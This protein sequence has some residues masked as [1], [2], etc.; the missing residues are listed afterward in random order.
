MGYRHTP[1]MPGE[2]LHYLDCKPGRTYVDGT[3][4][5][6][7]HAELICETIEPGG[8]LIG[9]DQDPDAISNAHE[10]LKP[11][12]GIVRL[13]HGSFTEIPRFLAQEGIHRVDGI[14]LDLGLSQHHLEAS[15]RGFSFQKDEPL[16]MRM[17][18]RR[19]QKAADI[20]NS[21]TASE[22]AGLFKTYGDERRSK[23]IARKIIAARKRQ[24]IE[25]SR[26]L[27]DIVCSAFPARGRKTQRIHP[28]TRVFMALRIAV[29][30][31][32]DRIREFMAHVADWLH[33]GGR[34]CVLAFH[35]SED[36][37]V[38][39]ALK[40]MSTGC[41]CPPGLPVCACGHQPRMRILTRKAVKPG[42]AEIEANPMAR[43]TRL[44]AAERIAE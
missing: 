24:P 42:Q 17:D 27:S 12:K 11:F 33:P 44:R 6:A 34:L 14:L 5:G 9:I 22:L 18:V 23:Q 30:Q 39:H 1:A 26:Q 7:G 4:G 15:G 16:D 19:P 3:L 36:R 31:E 29:N 32:L 40:K 25:T 43:S 2:V 35:S 20:V 37:I 38:K 10:L 41:I 8:I 13:F 28:A 21:L